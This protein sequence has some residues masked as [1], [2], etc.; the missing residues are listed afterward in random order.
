[1]TEP[2]KNVNNAITSKPALKASKRCDWNPHRQI[3]PPI[4]L[5]HLNLLSLNMRVSQETVNG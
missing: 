2:A 4:D 5:C 3:V 1:M